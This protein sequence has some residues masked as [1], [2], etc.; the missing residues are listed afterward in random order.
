MLFLK[1]TELASE[2]RIGLI[3]RACEVSG[4][5]D[6]RRDCGRDRTISGSGTYQPANIWTCGIAEIA[7]QCF[8]TRRIEG[9]GY[10]AAHGSA[11][12]HPI[13][14]VIQPAESSG[15]FG[16]AHNE[17]LFEFPRECDRGIPHAQ[18]IVLEVLHFV[19]ERRH[20][21]TRGRIEGETPI[22]KPLDVLSKTRIKI[23][24]YLLTELVAE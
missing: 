21:L 11:I 20:R 8:G 18:E 12:S 10:I 23:R 22:L 17:F 24:E 1:R 6:L 4:R 16:N 9:D 19:A 14:L 3:K 2:S 15:A 5:L 13:E 7:R